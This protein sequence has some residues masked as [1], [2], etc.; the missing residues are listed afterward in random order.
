ML[1]GSR[2]KTLAPQN[3]RISVVMPVHNALPYLDSAVECILGQTFTNFEF[4]ILDDASTDGTT[5]R[6]REW[7][8]ADLRI[9]LMEGQHNLGPARSSDKVARAARAPI[10]ARMDADDLCARDRLAIQYEVL[11]RHADVGVVG[12]L[13][14]MIDAAGRKIRSIDRWRLLQHKACAPV[15]HGTLMYRREVFDAAGGYRDECEYWEDLDLILRMTAISK[16]MVLPYS[17]YQNRLSPVSTRFASKEERVERALDR[18]YRARAR[19]EHNLPYDEA[20]NSHSVADVKLDPRVFI[21]I[22][23]IKL[24]TGS[25]PRFFRQLLKRGRLGFNFPTVSALVWTAWARLEPRSLRGFLRLLLRL[26][27]LRASFVIR[28]NE[29]IE[30]LGGNAQAIRYS[31]PRQDVY[32]LAPRVANVVPSPAAQIPRRRASSETI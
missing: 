26:R 15:A 17:T 4:V 18:M 14:E 1:N 16:M 9:R 24:W 5:V 30:W 21:S 31:G 3:P 2:I 22:G 20:L 12:S 28:S 19:L 29:P 7:A 23:S 25:R 6:L 32:V 10:V 11:Q 13:Y 27:N 8:E